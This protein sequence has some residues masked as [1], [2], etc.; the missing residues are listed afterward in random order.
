MAS[1]EIPAFHLFTAGV[2]SAVMITADVQVRLR[3]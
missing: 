3:R 1:H 2:L